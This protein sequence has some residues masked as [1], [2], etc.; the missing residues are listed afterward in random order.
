M[1]RI[2]EGEGAGGSGADRACIDSGSETQRTA[3]R[4]GRAPASGAGPRRL[5]SVAGNVDFAYLWAAQSVSQ[6]GTQFSVVVLPLLAALTLDASPMAV[7]LLAAAGGLPHLLFG[8]VAGAW[9]DRLPRRAVMIAADLGRFALLAAISLSAW[10]GAL[11]IELLIAIAFLAETLT[12]FFDIAY[13]A[14]VPAVV[15]REALVAANSRLEASASAAQVI[16]PAFGGTLMRLLGG[17][18]AMSVDALSYLASAALLLRISHRERPAEPQARPGIGSE[19]VEGL[20]ALWRD[21]VLRALALASGLVSLGGFIF[22]AVYVLYLTRDLGLDAGAV[23]LIFAGGGVGALIGSLAATPA[24]NRWGVGRT[25]VGALLLFG[26]FG[27]TVPLAILFPR[28]ALPL[29]L[30][31]E[32][33]Q[34]FTLVIYNINAVSLR[35][36]LTPD[37]LLGRVNGSIRFIS[38][39]MRPIGSL[40]GG[41]LGSQIG[42]PG[43]LVIGVCGMLLAFLPLLRISMPSLDDRVPGGLAPSASSR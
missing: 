4:R 5:L 31:S 24:R 2:S 1:G 37:H 39:G 32:L 20:S 22:L 36:A 6:I 26:I 28:Y 16:G 14:F 3:A 29:I 10:Q 34:W 42:L 41:F 23:G 9:V 35:Q 21:A 40:L 11:R 30:A 27:L 13:L 25:M 33:L 18:N 43:A 8:L 15:G 38:A 12:V 7:G 19:I 17:P